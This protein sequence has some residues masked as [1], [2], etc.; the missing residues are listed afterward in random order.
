MSS[1]VK[2]PRRIVHFSPTGGLRFPD[3][4]GCSPLCPPSGTTP[5]L[6]ANELRM[7][8]GQGELEEELRHG[9]GNGSGLTYFLSLSTRYSIPII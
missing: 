6:E 5:G 3:A 2:I 4:G 1:S 9:T 8:V 7:A